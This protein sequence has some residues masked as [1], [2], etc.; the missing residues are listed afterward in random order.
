MLASSK[1]RNANEP[2]R[3][4]RPANRDDSLET[5]TGQIADCADCLEWAT[6]KLAKVFN[7]VY[8]S[9]KDTLQGEPIVDQ[10]ISVKRESHEWKS[11]FN[12]MVTPTMTK[13]TELQAQ[14]TK[15][16][17]KSDD[18]EQGP[19]RPAIPA[20]TGLEASPTNASGPHDGRVTPL[21]LAHDPGFFLNSS[22]EHC[23]SSDSMRC[24]VQAR[25][26]QG[27]ESVV[28][29]ARTKSGRCRT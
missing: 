28:T 12:A 21:P 7:D 24:D 25:V 16:E 20:L 13:S 4:D 23:D 9:G 29:S 17:Q 19:R 2:C 22:N 8:K 15:F 6:P 26:A 27:D 11:S 5:R 18:R 14:C 1:P 3:T 10:L